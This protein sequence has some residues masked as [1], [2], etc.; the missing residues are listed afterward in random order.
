MPR[1]RSTIRTLHSIACRLAV[2]LLAVLAACSG[3]GG[4]TGQSATAPATMQSIEVT[5]N[6]AHVAA[7]TTAQFTAT[8]IFSDSTHRDIT[9]KV[10]WASSNMHTATVSNGGLASGLSAGSTMIS[11]SSAGMMGQTTLAVTPAFL[12][13]IEVTPPSSKVA[14]GT[15]AQFQAT[16]VFSDKSTQNLTSQVTWVSSDP[17]VATI[18]SATGSAGL[19]SAAGTGVTHISATLGSVSSPAASLTVTAATLASIQ[20]TP[21]SRSIAKGLSQQFTATGIFTDNSTQDLSS[22]VTWESSDTSIATISN[23]PGSAGLAFASSAGSS[24]ISATLG[25][26]T[27]PMVSLTVTSATLVSLQVTPPS[28]S[29]AN[30]LTEQFTATGVYTD[31]STQ[32]LTT[33]VTWAS[34]TASVASI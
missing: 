17:T 34:D 24:S 6:S 8:A 18:S 27:S 23:M 15:T 19:A 28:P 31:S 29:I 4:G 5:P 21:P 10:A 25:T 7:G 26:V 33:T 2:G 11:A 22:M 16:G 30:G 9:S 3:G 32:D 13:A 20:V 1:A 12:T 14:K